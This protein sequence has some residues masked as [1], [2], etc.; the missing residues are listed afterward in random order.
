[1]WPR[2][3]SLE[4]VAKKVLLLKENPLGKDCFIGHNLA[5]YEKGYINIYRIVFLFIIGKYIL[6]KLYKGKVVSLPLLTIDTGLLY[7][8]AN[9]AIGLRRWVDLTY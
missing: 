5:S 1:M 3:S 2:L 6:L 7:V 4:T 8:M 9:G